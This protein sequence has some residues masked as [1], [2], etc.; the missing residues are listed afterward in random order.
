MMMSYSAWVKMWACLSLH[1]LFHTCKKAHLKFVKSTTSVKSHSLCIF[2]LHRLVEPSVACMSSGGSGSVYLF[3]SSGKRKALKLNFAN[4]TVKPTSR[5]PLNPTPP[6]FQNPHM[7]VFHHVLLL[8]LCSFFF[9]VRHS[10]YEMFIYAET[11]WS[12]VGFTIQNDLLWPS[13]AAD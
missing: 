13:A 8:L 1:G 2:C 6:S 4:P 10:N 12:V 11:V 5:L 7:W 3:V 9:F